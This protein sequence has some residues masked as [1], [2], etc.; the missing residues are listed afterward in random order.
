MEFGIEECAMLVIEKGKIVKSA[1]RELPDGNVIKLL[2]DSE[3]HKY[4]RLLEAQK[5]LGED[6]R[7]KVSKEYFSRLKK[8]LK[9]KLNGRNLVQGV[10]ICEVSLLRISAAFINW[11]KCKL[12]AV[13]RTV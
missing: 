13:D 4:V 12:Q 9:S 7:L 5:C 10:N 1:G 11:R 8:V 3:S 2:Q 6:M